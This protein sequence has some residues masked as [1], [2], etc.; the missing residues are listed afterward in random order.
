VLLA[1]PGIHPW[2]I[3]HDFTAHG[4][5]PHDFTAH[6]IPPHDFTA[7]G[8]TPH[9][10]TAHGITPH[11]FT[12]HGITPHEYFCLQDFDPV[13]DLPRGPLRSSVERALPFLANPLADPQRDDFEHTMPR[14]K[15]ILNIDGVASAWRGLAILR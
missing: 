1:P 8:I 4:I 15:Y 2:G 7:H 11:D 3:P 5:T 14:F 13:G 9:D 12:A 10:F 6:G